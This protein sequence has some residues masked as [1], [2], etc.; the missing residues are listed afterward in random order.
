VSIR[1]KPDHAAFAGSVLSARYQTLCQSRI[2]PARE[3][4]METREL[5]RLVTE[6]RAKMYGD[7]VDLTDV[8]IQRVLTEAKRLYKESL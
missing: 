7:R 1:G 3:Y 5:L 6:T 4:P 8:E 2:L